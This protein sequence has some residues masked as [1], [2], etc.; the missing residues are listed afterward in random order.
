MAKSKSVKMPAQRLSYN[1]LKVVSGRIA[2]E[3]NADL[4]YPRSVDTYKKMFKDATIAP[5]MTYMEMSI[6]QSR[7]RVEYPEGS[8]EETKKRTELIRS[9]M[10]DMDCTWTDFIRGA[11]THNRFGFAPIE[12]IYRKRT[13]RNGSRYNDGVYGLANLVLIAQDSIDGW[14][15]SPD[16]RTLEGIEQ[17]TSPITRKGDFSYGQD[18]EIFIPRNKFLLFR[19]DPQ[20]DSPIGTSP[21][22]AVYTAWRY[23]VELE[24]FESTGV[25]QEM[26]GFKVIKIP[27]RYMADDASD[28]EKKTLE[29]FKDIL[30]SIHN[31]EQSGV[32]LPQQWDDNG[33]PLFEFEVKSVMGTNTHDINAI[34]QRYKK[35]IVSGILAPLM[36]SGQE[37]GGSFSLSESLKDIT[38]VVISARLKEIEQVLNHDLIPQIY[39]VNGWDME[40]LPY[41]TYEDFTQVTLDELS[42]T[43]QR[44]AS[45]GGL[46][47]GASQINWIHEQIGLP[48]AFDDEDITI[49]EVKELTTPT[50]SRAGD[51]MEVGKF[52]GTSD[53]VADEDTSISNLEN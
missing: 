28:E 40:V 14:R 38:D 53:K 2:E 44:V 1:A 13:K 7:W 46:V 3:C 43:L 51:G 31:G 42:K 32:L 52:S 49:E 45:V 50:T 5:A 22:D 10:D 48:K 25:S 4:T 24:R 41:F 21:L 30:R 34:I 47:M 37:G 27:P 33:K 6:A 9:M 20:K 39:Q 18:N 8:S 23:K 12:K 15:Y 11:A 17:K 29:T 19:A 35:E 26:R 36:M 16:G